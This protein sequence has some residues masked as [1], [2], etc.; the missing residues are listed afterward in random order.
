MSELSFDFDGKVAVVTGASTGFG[1]AFAEGFA[2]ANADVALG[3]R[4]VE[5]LERTREQVE[6]LGRQAVAVPTDVTDP[7]DCARLVEAAMERFGR[8]DILI[9]NA[10]TSN[11]APA[12]RED[13]DIF[14]HVVDVNLCGSF[15]MAQAC[16]RVMKPGSAIVNVG[17]V[18]GSTTIHLPQAAYISS[19]T[20]VNGL[21]RELAKQWTGNKGIRVN[22]VAP[23]FFPTEMTVGLQGDDLQKVIDRT[24]AGRLGELPEVV[25]AALFLAS[26]GASYVSGSVLTVD[27]GMLTG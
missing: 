8:V 9:N 19:K 26:D 14:R 18:M 27:G 17:S 7:V 15:Q 11:V 16:A 25:A 2:R 12:S 3:A 13:P 20:A 10:G 4:R 21:T 1:V 22:A 6:A 5:Q 24:P 23:A